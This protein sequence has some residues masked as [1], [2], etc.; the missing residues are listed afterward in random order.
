MKLVRRLAMVIAILSLACAAMFA[1][2]VSKLNRTMSNRQNLLDE[3]RHPVTDP[4]WQ[5][6]RAVAGKPAP[7][8][9][10]LNPQGKQVVLAQETKKGPVVLV[11]TKDD[12]PCSMEAQPFFN[13]LAK[14]FAD[15][16]TFFGVIDSKAPEASKYQD[17][18]KV[19]YQM[20]VS[21]KDGA[22]FKAYRAKRSVY[23]TLIGKDGVVVKQWPGYNR[24]MFVELDEEL[25]KVTGSR[26][27]QINTDMAPEKMN[28][29]CAFPIGSDE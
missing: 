28:S 25:A 9:D 7:N 17:D 27:I 10:L 18:F 20:L 12:C 13:E 26:A 19:P 15:K 2:E 16:V 29:G 4:M 11:F 14:G 22:I 24:A 8:F 1:F 5:S 23:T 6:A 21:D 3:P